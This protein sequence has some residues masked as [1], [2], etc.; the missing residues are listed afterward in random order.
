M[1]EGVGQVRDRRAGRERPAGRLRLHPVGVNTVGAERRGV[2]GVGLGDVVVDAQ[3]VLDGG[4]PLDHPAILLRRL[5]RVALA[6]QFR[7]EGPHPIAQL[8][9]RIAAAEERFGAAGGLDRL[10]PGDRVDPA[11]VASLVALLRGLG[12]G[13]FDPGPDRSLASLPLAVHPGPS[14]N[15]DECRGEHRRG[16]G[17][18]EEATPALPG[19]PGLGPGLGQLG[20]PEPPLDAAE[21]RRQPGDHRARVPRPVLRRGGEA[22]PRQPHQLRVGRRT[23][24]GAPPRPTGRPAS[25]CG[26][27]R[28]RTL[29]RTRAGR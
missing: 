27:P 9:A 21:I 29:P 16:Q 13:R 8:G 18:R 11:R 20:L 7:H 14:G 2:L 10:H 22:R 24:R 4:E 26:R 3:V 12:E 25:P 23:R 19:G 6:D 1:I 17:Q 28:P 5:G 15:A